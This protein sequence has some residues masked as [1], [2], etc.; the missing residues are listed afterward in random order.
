MIGWLKLN[1]KIKLFIDNVG[2][3]DECIKR[4]ATGLPDRFS[5]Y[6]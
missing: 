6:M 5:F 3:K 4:K 2:V 1:H